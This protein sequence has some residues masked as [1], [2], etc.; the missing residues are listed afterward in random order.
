MCIQV[1]WNSRLEKEH[2]RL[3]GLLGE[4][5]V[6]M[7]AMAGI[8]PFAVPAAQKGCRVS[9]VPC[10][11]CL[12]CVHLWGGGRARAGPKNMRCWYTTLT[13]NSKSQLAK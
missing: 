4:G 2:T 11:L 10:M 3:V 13:K 8:G 9:R 12:L 6:M 1:Y 7:D 5:E